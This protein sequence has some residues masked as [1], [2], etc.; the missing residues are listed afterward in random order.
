MK[1]RTY[2]VGFRS[3]TV[4]EQDGVISSQLNGADPVVYDSIREAA[5]SV[6][7]TVGGWI[8][9]AILAEAASEGLDIWKGVKNGQ[10][11]TA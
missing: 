10:S 4:T 11:G 7:D 1:T 9:L 3:L 6:G 2:R 8:K 5:V